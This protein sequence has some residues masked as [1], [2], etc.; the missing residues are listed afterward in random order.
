VGGIIIPK[1]TFHE[2]VDFSKEMGRRKIKEIESSS[3]GI[4]TQ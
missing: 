4:Y 3:K 1:D 2:F